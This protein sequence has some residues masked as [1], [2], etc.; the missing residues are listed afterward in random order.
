MRVLVISGAFVPA[1][2]AEADH[3]Y[4]TCAEL[5]RR[6]HRVDVLTTASGDGAAIDGYRRHAHHAQVVVVRIRHP[7]AHAPHYPPRCRAAFLFAE[8]VWLQL[9]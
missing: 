2:I 6:G 1:P 3:A 4:H 9:R 5:V 8:P 7:A